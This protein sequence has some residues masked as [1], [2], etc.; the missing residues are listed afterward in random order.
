MKK[1]ILGLGVLAL[2]AL[3]NVRNAS[4]DSTQPVPEPTSLVLL[5]LGVAGLV[6]YKIRS[7]RR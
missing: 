7:K 5:G 3:G 2:F 6:G 4:A 1:W